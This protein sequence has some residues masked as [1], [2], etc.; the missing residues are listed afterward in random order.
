MFK[1]LFS[2]TLLNFWLFIAVSCGIIL[3]NFAP[4]FLLFILLSLVCG[5]LAYFCYKKNRFLLSDIFTLF[6]FLFLGAL[7]QLPLAHQ[8]IE[9][10]LAK[11]NLCRIKVTSLPQ[12]SGL[13]NTFFAQVERINNIPLRTNIKVIDFTKSMD[14]LKTYEVEG[15]LRSRQYASRN[16]YF[17]WVKKG[18]LP[19]EIS[20]PI[21]DK[22]NRKMVF[23]ALSIFK[24]NLSDE[25][26]RFIASVFLGRRELFRQGGRVFTDAGIA[27]LLAISG[28]N[29]ALIGAVLFFVLKIFYIK[30]RPRILISLLFV[31][32][33][34]LI[35]GANLPTLRAVIMYS[36]FAVSFFLKRKMNPFNSLGLAGLVCLLF[37]PASLF[38][39]GFQLSFLSVFALILGFMLFPFRPGRFAILNC[40]GYTLFSSLYV[41]LIILPVVSYYFGRVYIG[42]ILYNIILI[43]FFSFILI[44]NFLLLIFSPLPYI[45]QSIGALLSLFIYI[46]DILAIRLGALRFSFVNY[47]FSMWQVV[48][49]YII[50]AGILYS[51]CR[52]RFAFLR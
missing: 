34:T 48:V 42:G 33:Y 27:H 30:F 21:W 11:N 25:G 39:V 14:Y 6:L 47:T 20:S 7:W 26:Y 9:Q 2:G 40:A 44:V 17:L 28:S 19:K 29:I 46:F 23:S 1:K 45:A 32:I 31:F 51:C 13:N 36:V 10:F 49:Y 52:S 3:G 5:A 18:T 24:R 50:L 15:A 4:S 43:P 22:F 12:E 35:T 41:S 38:D 37:N 8:E 16:F